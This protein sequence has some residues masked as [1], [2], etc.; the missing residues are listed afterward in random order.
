MGYG[1]GFGYETGL[2]EAMF[3]LFFTVIFVVVVGAFII[4]AVRG[5]NTWNKNNHSPVLTVEATVV[6]KRE[7]FYRHHHD[8]AYHAYTHYFV[9]FQ[10]QSGDR[11]EL[12]VQDSDYGMLCEGDR[13]QLTF[14]GTRYQ[15]FVRRVSA[16]EMG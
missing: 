10:V 2:F 13:G 14:Q 7:Q 5:L 11:L 12:E 3:P 15:G 1:F 16:Y 4:A 8:H 9:T 6:T